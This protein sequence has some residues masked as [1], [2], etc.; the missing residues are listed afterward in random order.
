MNEE[1]SKLGNDFIVLGRQ[2]GKTNTTREIIEDLLVMSGAPLEGDDDPSL[3]DVIWHAD[4]SDFL[5]D[6]AHIPEEVLQEIIADIV[7]GIDEQFG[8]DGSTAPP[9]KPTIT[10][11]QEQRDAYD[12]AMRGL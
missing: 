3:D 1:I 2:L 6:I 4:D 12:R 5:A 7:E 10:K 8:V 9:S 11:E